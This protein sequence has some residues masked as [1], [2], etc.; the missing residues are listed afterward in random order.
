M[1][2]KNINYFLFLKKKYITI[3]NYLTEI[4][5]SYD[6]LA[7]YDKQFINQFNKYENEVSEIKYLINN[8]N[9]T[10]CILCDHNFVEDEIDITPDRS[11]K[12]EYCTICEYSKEYGFTII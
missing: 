1:D 7:L 8:V 11:Q 12:I 10:I 2:C 4:I 3:L 6:E 5:I 9:N